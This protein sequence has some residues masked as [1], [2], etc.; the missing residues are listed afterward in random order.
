VFR[1]LLT[2]ADR[3]AHKDELAESIWPVSP[4]KDAAHR[5]H[6]AISTLRHYL[7][8]AS[9]ESYLVL[10]AGWY[11]INPAAEL[12]D[13]AAIFEQNMTQANRLWNDRELDAAGRVY[14]RAIDSYSGDY[15]IADLDFSWASCERE[16]LLNGYLT[17]M[18]RLGRLRLRQ[19]R[20]EDAVE[21]LS[22]LLDRDSY[23]EDVHF[24]LMHCYCL[25]GRR[26][27]AVQ[28]Y[29][30]CREL[31]GSALGISPTPKL[32]DLYEAILESRERLPGLEH[33]ED[34]QLP[35]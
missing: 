28:Q 6:V 26:W 34:P 31:L 23:R 7:D 1:Y 25:L 20:Y 21:C 5:L 17:A 15:C 18:Y 33:W 22:R 32:Q 9:E 29:L 2:R 35:S 27:Q 14:T 4:P 30:K 8:P 24:H 12:T 3:M 10:A 11:R 16:H 13:D 19:R